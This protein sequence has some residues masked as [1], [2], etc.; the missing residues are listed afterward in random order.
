MGVLNLNSKLK[1]PQFKI[2]EQILITLPQ[3]NDLYIYISSIALSSNRDDNIHIVR[4]VHYNDHDL[5]GEF[6]FNI[7]INDNGHITPFEYHVYVQP[8]TVPVGCQNKLGILTMG[9]DN[10]VNLSTDKIR[11][12]CKAS[13][14]VTGITTL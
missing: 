12:Q 7:K 13:Y 2:L 14:V 9:A 5:N 6:H 11:C 8:I 4:G 10:S 3:I 1:S